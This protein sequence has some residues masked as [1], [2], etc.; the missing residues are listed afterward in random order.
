MARDAR[1]CAGDP[2]RAAEIVACRACPRLVAWREQVAREAGGV[3]RRGV[4][5]PARARLRRPGRPRAGRRPG[6]RGPR[7]QPHR[8]DVHRR[9]LRRLAVRRP[10]P[11]R[12]T[13]TSPR[14]THRR[15]RPRAHRRLHHRAGA[16]R[17]AGQQADARRAGHLPA[18]PRPRAG[19]AAPTCGWSWRSARSAT[20]AAAGALGVRPRPRFGHGVEVA[21]RATAATLLCSY[22]VSQQNTFTGRLTE[23]MLDAVFARARARHLALAGRTVPPSPSVTPD[24]AEHRSTVQRRAP[25]LCW[26]FDR[27]RRSIEMNVRADY[28]NETL[29]L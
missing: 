11:G 5:G 22:H 15:R 20:E 28:R 19:A 3:P 2:A 9:P 25:R 7:R 17:A 1:R 29:A 16:L 4:L 14:A 6:A 23:P 26:S 21:A 10:A 27:M 12:A 18:V 8:S 24:P 13:P